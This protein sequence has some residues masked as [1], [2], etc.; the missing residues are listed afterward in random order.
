MSFLGNADDQKTKLKNITGL[1]TD[2]Y[3]QEQVNS[4][5]TDGTAYLK[6]RTDQNKAF[7]TAATEYGAGMFEQLK[8][9]GMSEDLA[10]Q[11]ASEVILA[12][13]R[14]NDAVLDFMYPSALNN[15]Y[16]ATPINARAIES[17]GSKTE[18]AGKSAAGLRGSTR[19]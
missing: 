6:K 11:K 2:E 5:L 19:K 14:A 15:N 16:S 18:R 8:K 1:G 3:T 12:L 7:N 10:Q 9:T 17:K 13:K 4:A